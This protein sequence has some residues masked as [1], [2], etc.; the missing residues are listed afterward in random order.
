[1]PVKLKSFTTADYYR[2]CGFSTKNFRAGVKGLELE[3]HHPSGIML[4]RDG[5]PPEFVPIHNVRSIT[6]ENIEDLQEALSGKMVLHTRNLD[7]AVE[8]LKDAGFAVTLVD[9]D[10]STIVDGPIPKKKRKRRTKAEM[11]AA[12]AAAS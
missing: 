12:R 5:V 3:Y 9:K 2:A 6:P 7:N 10:N 1:M 4:S 11:E 8:D